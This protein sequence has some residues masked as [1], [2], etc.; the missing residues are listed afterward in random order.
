MELRQLL[1]QALPV[2]RAEVLEF[3]LDLLNAIAK[4]S[5]QNKMTSKNLATV[6]LPALFFSV[7]GDSTSPEEIMKMAV[8]G[9]A[10]S[11]TL[12]FMIDNPKLDPECV[13]QSS[14]SGSIT[15]PAG[16]SLSASNLSA[17]KLT[18]SDSSRSHPSSPITTLK[19][20]SRKRS[21]TLPEGPHVCVFVFCCSDC[22]P[23]TMF[24]ADCVLFVS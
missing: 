12:S 18:R 23:Q 16:A 20:G 6:F 2:E 7:Q 22:F 14:G 4:R 13:E 11:Q 5:D 1:D 21:N 10:V 8:L 15:I 17:A 3:T 24:L 19:K 9:K